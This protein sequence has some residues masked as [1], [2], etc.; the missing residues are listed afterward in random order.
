MGTELENKKIVL[1]VD[2]LE[3]IRKFL[4]NEA[5]YN[6]KTYSLRQN[7]NN[8]LL[9]IV[10]SSILRIDDTEIDAL[11]KGIKFDIGIFQKE[12]KRLGCDYFL[13]ITLS[14]DV[15]W[16]VIK[17]YI[18]RATRPPVQVD[19]QGATEYTLRRLP[20]E[21]YPE[22]TT[23]NSSEFFLCS[24]LKEDDNFHIPQTSTESNR[25]LDSLN[26]GN[27]ELLQ[28]YFRRGIHPGPLISDLYFRQ[29]KNKKKLYC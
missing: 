19:P 5:L 16:K 4:F 27:Y 20:K 13:T 26:A 10:K 28:D 8:G 2:E 14:E 6:N 25:L 9:Q 15:S 18:P 21:L 22:R 7:K 17:N 1:T 12:K 11:I 24:N 23:S 3:I 29:H